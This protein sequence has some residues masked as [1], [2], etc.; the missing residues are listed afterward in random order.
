MLHRKYCC[1][2]QH[3]DLLSAVHRLERG[4]QCHLRLTESDIAAKQSVHRM[5]VL[6]VFFYLR[7]RL[8][9]TVR[10]GPFE[11]SLEFVLHLG[12]G[13]E[14]ISLPVLPCGIKRDKLLCDILC[15]RFRT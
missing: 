8:K 14:R 2:H 4:A 1:R 7:R 15:S 5:R 12:I 13:S 10:L 11:H 9:L 3:R 6:H